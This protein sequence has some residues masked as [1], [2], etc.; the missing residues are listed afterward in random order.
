MAAERGPDF[1]IKYN[2]GLLKHTAAETVPVA[3]VADHLCATDDV[4]AAALQHARE[5]SQPSSRRNYTNQVCSAV[6]F[7]LFLLPNKAVRIIL[8][9]GPTTW[10]VVSHI[11]LTLGFRTVPDPF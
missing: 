5:S 7:R 3:Q 1:A 2:C 4:R 11:E 6:T 8:V 9:L 10:Y